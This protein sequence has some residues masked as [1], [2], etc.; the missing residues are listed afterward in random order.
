M[1]SVLLAERLWS[2]CGIS[3]ELISWDIVLTRKVQEK[4]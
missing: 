1:K 4:G 3:V 2:P